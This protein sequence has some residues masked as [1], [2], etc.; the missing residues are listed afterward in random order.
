MNMQTLYVIMYASYMFA[1][2]YVSN[3]TLVIARRD[4]KIDRESDQNTQSN[5]KVK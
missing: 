2:T 5:S 1:D 4:K 3:K